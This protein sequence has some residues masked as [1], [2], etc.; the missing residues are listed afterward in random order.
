MV[1]GY[2]VFA[3]PRNFPLVDVLNE[4]SCGPGKALTKSGYS[5]SD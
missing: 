3:D 5:K 1:Y 4:D 2:S